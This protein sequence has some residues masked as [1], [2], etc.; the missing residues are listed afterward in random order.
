MLRELYIGVIDCEKCIRVMTHD[1]HPY[2]ALADH[3]TPTMEKS[4]QWRTKVWDRAWGKAQAEV[5]FVPRF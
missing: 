5:F 1:Y 4:E 3:T 2:S